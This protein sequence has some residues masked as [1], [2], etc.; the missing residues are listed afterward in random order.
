ML[1]IVGLIS[2]L[3]LLLFACFQPESGCL[4]I[5]ATNFAPAADENCGG[6]DS[7]SDCPCTYPTISFDT[8]DYAFTKLE[9]APDTFYKIDSQYIRITSIRFYLS[10]FQFIR[11]NGE[12]LRVED[13]LSLVV[14]NEEKEIETDIFLDD[15]ILVNQQS[16]I[17]I[18]DLKES[19]QFDSLRF[20]VG[21]E[22]Q[23]NSAAP[24]SIS[25]TRHALAETSMHTS[26]QELGY[27]FNQIKLHKDTL[28]TTSE[29]IINISGVSNLVEVKMP[30]SYKTT[31]G[32]NFSLGTIRIDYAEWLHGINFAIDSDAVLTQKIV[33][34]T[35]NAFSFSN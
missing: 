23:A 26:S 34:N 22:G 35:P 28:P 32:K 4:D 13:T 9:Y 33:E 11:E 14:L 25:D 16:R 20:V 1:R 19:G 7:N 17:S 21:I 18:G 15:F 10:G 31:T 12:H 27:I 2:L 8:V 29:T 30:F 24:D 5:E 6:D 3:S